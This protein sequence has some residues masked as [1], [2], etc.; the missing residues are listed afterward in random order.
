MHFAVA[1]CASSMHA[2]QS[3]RPH[4]VLWRNTLNVPC[5][6]FS[7]YQS[8]HVKTTKTLYVHPIASLIST[9]AYSAPTPPGA[10]PFSMTTSKLCS[11]RLISCRRRVGGSVHRRNSGVEAEDESV[12]GGRGQ[13][14]LG[15]WI[16][17]V[18]KL[19]GEH[20][21]ESSQPCL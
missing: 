12:T 13:A 19:E 1:K 15:K 7:Q 21:V 3:R 17:Q 18:S 16:F 10:A 5:V 14:F 11:A 20:V 6:F 9:T 8:K 2:K 4:R